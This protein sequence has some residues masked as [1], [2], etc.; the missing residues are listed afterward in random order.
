VP[1]TGFVF[2]KFEIIDFWISRRKVGCLSDLI[3]KFRGGKYFGSRQIELTHFPKRRGWLP[4]NF[5]KG[6]SP[7]S[8]RDY[9][10]SQQRLQGYRHIYHPASEA[11]HSL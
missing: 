10:R 2:L 4:V 3:A 9:L 7:I 6:N 8:R 5:V 11:R 1:G